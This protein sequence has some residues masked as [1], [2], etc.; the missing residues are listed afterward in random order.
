M[1]ASGSGMDPVMAEIIGCISCGDEQRQ[2]G[3][4]DDRRKK[5]AP[6]VAGVI[7]GQYLTIT[8]WRQKEVDLTNIQLFFSLPQAFELT[9]L[10]DVN[11]VRD[12]YENDAANIQHNSLALCPCRSAM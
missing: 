12:D 4:S 6:T 11:S 1:R 9:E 10:D 3:S 8:W 7:V 2:Q 5:H